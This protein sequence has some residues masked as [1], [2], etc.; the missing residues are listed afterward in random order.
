MREAGETGAGVV[1]EQ[2]W[3]S[4]WEDTEVPRPRPGDRHLEAQT[5]GVSGTARERQAEPQRHRR[6]RCAGRSAQKEGIERQIYT[7]RQRWA[8]LGREK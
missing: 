3:V 8:Y 6:N 4:T 2:S 5:D 1:P 7:V